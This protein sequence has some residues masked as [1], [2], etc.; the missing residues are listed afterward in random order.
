MSNPRAADP[1]ATYKQ[2]VAYSWG[3]LRQGHAVASSEM[4]AGN[5]GG[6]EAHAIWNIAAV[7]FLM[8]WNGGFLAT[9]RRCKKCKEIP[10]PFGGEVGT[11]MEGKGKCAICTNG[12][13][14]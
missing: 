9:K 8:E 11:E 10:V 2:P 5:G 14:H 4:P 13:F 6:S 12:R 3:G 7:G 1:S